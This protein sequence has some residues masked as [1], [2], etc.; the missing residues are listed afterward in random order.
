MKQGNLK[1]IALPFIKGGRE[2][3]RRWIYSVERFRGSR[4]PFKKK[5]TWV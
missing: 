5:W 1:Q 4:S 2:G 3:F